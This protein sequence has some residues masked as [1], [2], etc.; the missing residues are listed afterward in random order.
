SGDLD[1]ALRYYNRAMMIMEEISDNN[2]PTALL[3]RIALHFRVMEVAIDKKDAELAR[4]HF[5]RVEK[6]YEQKPE[7]LALKCYYKIGK[8][9]FLQASKRARDW[10]K[11]EE[12]FKEVIESELGLF[13]LKTLALFGLCELLLVELK[14]TGEMDVINEVKPLI[15]KLIDIA[16]QW[17]SDSYLIEAFILQGK[18][19]LLTFDIK[20]ARRFL[21]QAQRI[22]ESRGYKG[23][24]DEIARLRLD[25]KGKLDAWER[26]KETNAPLSER[27]ELAQLDDHTT[28]QFRKRIA[29]MERVEQKEVTVYKDLKTC[30]VCKGDVEGFNVFICP[31]C[32]SI[33]CRTCAE[34]VIEIENACWTCESAIDMSRPSKPFEQEEEEITSEEKSETKAPKSYDNK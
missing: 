25:L 7:D 34:A 24:A 33:Y 1:E 29:R 10:V 26:L 9:S 20:T 22:A 27:I 11:A 23:F 30:L 13:P 6:I 5:E 2:D 12:L 15:E 31:Q 8:A 19:A 21:I 32:D 14:M 16:Q 4:K 3:F 17:K 28:G 18:M